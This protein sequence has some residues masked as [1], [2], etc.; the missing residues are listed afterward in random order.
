M[1]WKVF[2]SFTSTPHDM[3]TLKYFWKKVK[4]FLASPTE[5][6]VPT[7]SFV[8]AHARHRIEGNKF[9]SALS[10]TDSYLCRSFA[11][12]LPLLLCRGTLFPSQIQQSR[13]METV[14]GNAMR[15]PAE[16]DHQLGS[17]RWTALVFCFHKA[18]LWSSVTFPCSYKITSWVRFTD[19][20]NRMNTSLFPVPS[21]GIS[22]MAVSALGSAQAFFTPGVSCNMYTKEHCAFVSSHWKTRRTI[23]ESQPAVSY[24]KPIATLFLI[25]ITLISLPRYCLQPRTRKLHLRRLGT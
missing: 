10:V 22:P 25:N 20:K 4:Q 2:Q 19:G 14:T 8:Q 18:R 21:C 6:S 7:F 11:L 9:A 17:H 15:T 13:K 23:V 1:E 5:R 3:R 24:L 16:T 12:L